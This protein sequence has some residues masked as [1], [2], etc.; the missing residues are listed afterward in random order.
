MAI[1]LNGTTGITAPDIDVTAQSTDITTTGDI[2]AVD[3]TLSGGVYL[4]GTGSA[5]YLD[6]VEYGTWSPLYRP[7]SGAFTTMTMNV[8]DASY[9]KIGSHVFLKAYIRTDNVVIGSASGGLTLAGLPF[10]NDSGYG[11]FAS[12]YHENW[13]GTTPVGGYAALGQNFIQLQ[14]QPTAGG[15]HGTSLVTD[16]T[17][18]A[19]NTR[20]RLMITGFYMTNS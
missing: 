10:T 19:I 4:G 14:T 11:N 6:D 8:I 12:V 13:S 1:T 18:G 15:A 7:S 2:T 17:T 16:L 20:N 9:M 3:A 5:N